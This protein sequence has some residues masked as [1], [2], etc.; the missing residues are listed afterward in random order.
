MSLLQRV[1]GEILG[2]LKEEQE[3]WNE[4]EG[5]SDIWLKIQ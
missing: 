2:G 3:I 5:P 1:D 4:T